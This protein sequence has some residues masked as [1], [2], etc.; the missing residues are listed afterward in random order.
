MP[1]LNKRLIVIVA[2]LAL[3][4]ADAS[5]VFAENG[6]KVLLISPKSDL[7]PTDAIHINVR[8]SNETGEQIAVSSIALDCPEELRC[9]S[10]GGAKGQYELLSGSEEQ[11]DIEPNEHHDFVLSAQAVKSSDT[12]SEQW[13]TFEARD[14]DFN[15]KLI[16]TTGEGQ[17]QQAFAAVEI[18]FRTSM[19]ILMLGAVVGVTLITV[20]DALRRVRRWLQEGTPLRG[21]RVSRSRALRARVLRRLTLIILDIVLGGLAAMT[22]ILLANQT[23]S[24][25]HVLEIRLLDVW[26]G[27]LIGALVQLGTPNAAALWDWL[28]V[29]NV[30]PATA[31]SSQPG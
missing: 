30:S 4:F 1:T 31:G 27:F 19:S 2:C 8:I 5:D 11:V 16:Y 14:Y 15:I 29:K 26:G 21:R 3:C 6:V 23:T 18:P 25:D 12:L 28:R 22:T 7:V 9:D 13:L 17:Q 20:I 24:L 10:R